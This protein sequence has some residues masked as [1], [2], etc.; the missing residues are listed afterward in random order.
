MTFTKEENRI[1]KNFVKQIQATTTELNKQDGK[2]KDVSYSSMIKK[3]TKEINDTTLI[4]GTVKVADIKKL[5]KIKPKETDV[6]ILI[7]EIIKEVDVTKLNLKKQLRRVI[8]ASKNWG[9]QK[10]V[11]K[12][13]KNKKKIVKEV[14]EEDGDKHI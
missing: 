3:I 7:K 14:K 4:E 2:V 12:A 8:M 11:E 6:A 5:V 10:N 13:P 9:R 1:L